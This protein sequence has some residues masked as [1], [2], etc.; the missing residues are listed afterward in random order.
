MTTVAAERPGLSHPPLTFEGSEEALRAVDPA[1]ILTPPW[2]LQKII[3]HDRG[4][5]GSPFTV[6]HRQIH[7]IDRRRLLEIANDENLTLPG[8]PPNLPTLIL[9][10]RP[11]ADWIA[12][13]PAAP[14]L[15]DYWRLLF[16]ARVDAELHPKLASSGGSAIEARIERIGPEAFKE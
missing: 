3:S 16:H 2:L 11:E 12:T 6:A 7:L 5:G 13:H 4:R 15:R 14:T 10:V 9:L 1:V 8:Y